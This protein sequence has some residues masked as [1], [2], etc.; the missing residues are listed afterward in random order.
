MPNLFMRISSQLDE[1]IKELMRIEGYISRAEF[2]R[3]LIKFYKYHGEKQSMSL[4]DEN[5]IKRGQKAKWLRE[6]DGDW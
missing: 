6:G 3:F 4:R 5:D 2:I 1:E